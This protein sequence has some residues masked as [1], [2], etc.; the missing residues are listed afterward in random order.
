M[1]PAEL[2]KLR[3]KQRKARRKAELERQQAAQ[4]QEKREHHNKSRQQGEAEPDAPPQDELV[5]E[6]LA[7]TE[8]PLE[9]AM[10]FL[11]PLQSLAAD[12]IETHL[13]AFEIFFRKGRPLLMLQSI[14]RAFRLDPESPALHSCLVRF[15]VFLARS[16]SLDP[17]VTE[18]V[19]Q[20]TKNIFKGRDARQLNAQFLARHGRSLPAR[21]E[22]ARMMYLLEPSSQDSAISLATALDAE[23]EKVDLQTCTNVLEALRD[24]EFGPCDVQAEDYMVRCR[25]RFPYAQIFR[26]PVPASE[27]SS[28]ISVSTDAPN[29]HDNYIN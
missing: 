6:K 9:Q 29:N 2:K 13:M 15:L 4:A 21:L 20:E 27:S 11:T 14:K 3:N 19:N 5:P 7:R 22:V 1:A 12:R 16:G 24:G 18:V 8:E 23:L 25:T 17:A 10:R 26:P 28:P